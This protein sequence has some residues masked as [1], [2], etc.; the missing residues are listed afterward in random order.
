[1]ISNLINISKITKRRNTAWRLNHILPICSERPRIT[2]VAKMNRQDS[3]SK[4]WGNHEIRKAAAGNEPKTWRVLYLLE[5]FRS[6]QL[7]SWIFYP[8][9][10]QIRQRHQELSSHHQ[11]IWVAG[12]KPL[13]TIE[14][15]NKMN[16]GNRLKHLPAASG[17]QAPDQQMLQYNLEKCAIN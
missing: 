10:H 6:I 13:L 3:D 17:S 9:L 7:K 12:T 5:Y 1:M 14:T 15:V 16:R 2:R 8:Q 4:C 11:G